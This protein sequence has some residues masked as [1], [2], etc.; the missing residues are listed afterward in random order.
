MKLPADF[1]P[2]RAAILR[3]RGLGDIVLSS[4]VIDALGRAYPGVAID[5]VA[6]KPARDLLARDGRLDGT[7]LVGLDFAS[8]R[9]VIRWLRARRP[10]LVVDLFSNP[11]TALITA[12]SGAPYRIGLDKRARRYAYNV[13][14]PRRL[15]EEGGER[16]WAAEVQLDFLREAGVHWE[17]TARPSVALDDEDRAFA[18]RALRELGYPEGAAFGAVLPGGSWESKRWS[19]EGFSAA[20]RELHAAT[21][22]LTLVLWGPPERDEARAIVAAAGE[23]RA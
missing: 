8:T 15:G 23:E 12:F 1:A 10:D 19:V 9:A 6:E 17:G 2:R 20:A 5:F 11:R 18:L 4:A 13:R 14:V 7:F 3:P 21:G 16:R 22:Q